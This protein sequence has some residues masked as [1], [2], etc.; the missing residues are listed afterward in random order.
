M[1]EVEGQC[2]AAHAEEA[3]AP[4][5]EGLWKS[6]MLPAE[7]LGA[8]VGLVVVGGVGLGAGAE[9]KHAHITLRGVEHDTGLE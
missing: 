4:S 2:V 6:T 8:G 5:V 9:G 7:T 3:P 1:R